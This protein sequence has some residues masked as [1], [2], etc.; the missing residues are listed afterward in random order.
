MGV[1]DANYRFSY[2]DVGAY[3]SEG[4]ASV[5]FKSDFGCSIIH[6][7]IDLPEDTEIFSK[8]L[9]F[10]FVADDAFPLTDRIM[11]PYTP[12]RN[13]TLTEQEKIFNYR[14]SRARRVVENAF[15]ILS[16]K[17]ICLSRTLFCSPERAQKIVAACC[18]LHN[19]FLNNSRQ[20]YCPSNFCDRYDENGILIEGEWRRNT[21]NH[22][23]GLQTPHG[24]SQIQRNVNESSK[25]IRETFKQFVNS[26]QGSLDWQRRA[27]FLD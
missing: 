7:T 8:K 2:I 15:G 16:A 6:D 25:E 11:K 21:R 17:F 20:S 27:V 22:M 13:G 18:I 5:F 9:P 10:V 24:R 19:Y 3:G 12:P 23:I 1:A 14:L 4:D 26:P